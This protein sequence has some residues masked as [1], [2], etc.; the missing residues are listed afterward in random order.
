[1]WGGKAYVSG[2]SA[3]APDGSFTGPF[4][5]VP[6]EVSLEAA[7]QAAAR[8]PCRSSAASSGRWVIW[9]RVTAWLMVHGMVNA[10]PGYSQTTPRHQWLLGPDR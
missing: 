8:R 6:I 10:D 5:T 7:Q 2:H 3:Q 9:D 4:G 1:V